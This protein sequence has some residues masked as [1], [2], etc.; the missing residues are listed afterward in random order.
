MANGVPGV[1]NAR[2]LAPHLWR[3]S[4]GGQKL[5][6]GQELLCLAKHGGL[7]RAIAAVFT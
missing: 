5:C 1:A 7:G 3:G 6:Q 2:A 4:L